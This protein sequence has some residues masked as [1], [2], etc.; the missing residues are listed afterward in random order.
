MEECSESVG[1]MVHVQFGPRI[2]LIHETDMHQEN[3]DAPKQ[4]TFSSETQEVN[5][6]LDMMWAYK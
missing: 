3:Q 4:V 1:R 2:V 5:Y 6:T